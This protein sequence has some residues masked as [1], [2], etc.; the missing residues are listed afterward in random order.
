[1]NFY[2]AIN[3]QNMKNKTITL[4]N[5]GL[6]NLSKRLFNINFDDILQKS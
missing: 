5:E 3:M 1:M 2:Q 4:L 6:L